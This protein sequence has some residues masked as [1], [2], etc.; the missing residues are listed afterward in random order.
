MSL[1]KTYREKCAGFP[2]EKALVCDLYIPAGEPGGPTPSGVH[3]RWLGPC[4]KLNYCFFVGAW[5][6][7]LE[8]HSRNNTFKIA[9]DKFWWIDIRSLWLLQTRDAWHG[10]LSYWR[11]NLPVWYRTENRFFTD[12]VLTYSLVAQQ[13]L[14]DPLKLKGTSFFTKTHAH[15][16]KY[17]VIHGVC[18][19]HLIFHC[20][21]WFFNICNHKFVVVQK[22]QH[23]SF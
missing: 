12:V 8:K 4:W 19:L 18:V 11:D 3:L 15:Y 7:H 1:L 14:L 22:M 9:K 23:F 5:W 10:H 2:I 20:Q 21:N 6:S 16:N 17:A 13:W